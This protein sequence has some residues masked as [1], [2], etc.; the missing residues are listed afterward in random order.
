MKF[1]LLVEGHTEHN[2]VPA[3][4]KRWLDARLQQPV[5]IKS[6]LFEGWRELA[7]DMRQKAHMHLNGSNCR[8][9]I[10]VIALLDLYGPTFYPRNTESA[11]DRYAWGKEH[12]ERLV[13][14]EKFRH[15]FAVHETE[16]WLLSDPNVFPKEIRDR[17]HDRV[18]RPETVNFNE[19]PAVLLDSLYRQATNKSY[20]KVVYGKQLFQKLD[21]NIAYEKCPR[22]KAMLDE[23]LRLAQAAVL[24]QAQ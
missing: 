3:F 19:P 13:G 10:A 23:M 8:D 20:K 2:A 11:A 6:V 14:H 15:F 4:L 16:A 24:A 7:A 22:L 5:G 12:F 18:N 1:I 9:V 17:L 21:P